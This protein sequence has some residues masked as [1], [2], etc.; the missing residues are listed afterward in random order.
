MNPAIVIA[1][2]AG[3]AVVAVAA[4]SPSIPSKSEPSLVDQAEAMVTIFKYYQKGAGWLTQEEFENL[5]RLN[6][7]AKGITYQTQEEYELAIHDGEGNNLKNTPH[8]EFYYAAIGM[9]WRNYYLPPNYEWVEGKADMFTAWSI[10]PTVKEFLDSD[11]KHPPRSTLRLE[12]TY[13]YVGGLGTPEGEGPCGK[14]KYWDV[15]YRVVG[16][17]DDPKAG[18]VYG[19]SDL[20]AIGEGIVEDFK[21]AVPAVLRAIASVASNYPGI[22]TAIAAGATFLAEVGSGASLD[23]AALAAGRAAIPSALTGAYDIGV[24]LAT[25]GE[26]DAAEALKVAMAMAISQGVINGDVLEQFETIKQAYNDYQE[27][28]GTTLVMQGALE[29]AT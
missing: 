1:L 9:Y 13:R 5:G 15:F 3:A 14:G 7:Q 4:S 19:T 6:A 20:M 22:G 18:T 24:G 27:V 29:L 8:W 25:K 28:K 16:S 21:G 2:L 17:L 12:C 23:E 11:R 10:T 26:L